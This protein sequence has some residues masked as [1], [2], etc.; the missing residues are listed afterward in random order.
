MA[1]PP[2]PLREEPPP[3]WEPAGQGAQKRRMVEGPGAELILYRLPPGTRF[4]LHTHPNSELGVVLSGEGDMLLQDTR[5]W[6][7]P[8]D[9]FFIPPRTPHGFA[10][11]AKGEPVVILN[12]DVDV[13]TDAVEVPSVIRSGDVAPPR[14]PRSD[15]H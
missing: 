7:R 11:P 6:V 15:G 8:G 1:V 5:R 9:S 12:A 3:K 13:P 10:V 4:E 14:R 2:S